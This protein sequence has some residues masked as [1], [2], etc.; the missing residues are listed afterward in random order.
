MVE[1]APPNP[2]TH[3]WGGM[4]ARRGMGERTWCCYNLTRWRSRVVALGGVSE[5]SD[6]PSP[7]LT[8]PRGT[9]PLTPRRRGL[10]S[11]GSVTG[12]ACVRVGSQ[13]A[14]LTVVCL[15]A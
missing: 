13:S 10:L 4:R 15:R 1:R 7:R 8:P 14:A 2:Y 12:R 6:L 11:C 3:P 9:V 5:F